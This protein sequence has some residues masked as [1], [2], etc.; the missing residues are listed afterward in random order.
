[1]N[2]KSPIRTK[3]CDAA[4][5]LIT[6]LFPITTCPASITLLAITHPSPTLA[7]CPT[8]ALTM[9]RLFDP[10]RVTPPPFSVPA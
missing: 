1:M 3:W 4:P 10:T 7:S 2:T 5:A 8:W 6:T 9:S